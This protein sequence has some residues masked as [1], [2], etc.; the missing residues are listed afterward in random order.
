[1]QRY[2]R[3]ASRLGGVVDPGMCG[4]PK[5]GNREILSATFLQEGPVGEGDCRSPTCTPYRKS[6]E[7]IVP[8]KQAN[9][10][11][12]LSEE[13]VEERTSTKRNTDQEATVRTQRRVAVSS[14]L[15]GVRQAAMH[16]KERVFTALLHHVTYDLL[17]DSF[18]KL[19][20]HAAVG[21]DGTTWIEYQEH[22]EA[23]ISDLHDRV[24]RGR[25]WVRF[26]A[27]YSR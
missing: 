24:H 18:K 9:K 16:S 11:K 12:R 21:I 5:R 19:K 10:G 6:D 27:K 25:P 23:N 22:A 26:D 8:K 3:A 1:M 7:V 2:L 17:F 4:H 15:K 20:K 14:G 13:F